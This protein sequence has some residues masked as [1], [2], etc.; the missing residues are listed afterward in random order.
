M[1]RKRRPPSVVFLTPAQI[2][3]RERREKALARAA[4]PPPSPLI[5]VGRSMVPRS[6]IAGNEVPVVVD[7]YGRVVS[8]VP[9]LAPTTIRAPRKPKKRTTTRPGPIDAADPNTPE[10]N[11]GSGA[12]ATK[13]TLP[14]Q[15]TTPA[16]TT[17]TTPTGPTPTET[18]K[19]QAAN[20]GLTK[21]DWRFARWQ[22]GIGEYAKYGPR[23][24]G[25]RPSGYPARTPQAGWRA[26]KWYQEHARQ[27]AKAPKKTTEP[28]ETLAAEETAAATAPAMTDQQFIN[29]WA[30]AFLQPELTAQQ[31][32]EARLLQQQ[33][34]HRA[35]FQHFTN[36]LM[37]ELKG[38]PAGV[39][40]DY[41]QAGNQTAALARESAAGLAAA[42]PNAQTQ[43]LMADVGAPASQMAQAAQAN[44]DVYQGGSAVLFGT[45]GHLPARDLFG[46]GASQTAYARML[47]A[48]GAAQAQDN[49]RAMGYTQSQERQKAADLRAQIEAKR[50]GYMLQGQEVLDKRRNDAAAI[51]IQQAELEMK[52]SAAEANRKFMEWSASDKSRQAWARIYGY[53]ERGNPTLDT[54]IADQRRTDQRAVEQRRA[55]QQA[56]STRLRMAS[57][58]GYD[59]ETMT[60]TLAQRQAEQR[61]IENDRKLKNKNK[62]GG[63]TTAQV[64]KFRQLA[65]ATAREA[66]YGLPETDNEEAVPPMTYQEAMNDL[67]MEM[68]LSIAQ[69]ALN[70]YYKRGDRG[71][72]WLDYQ[73]RQALQRAGL[74]GV[75]EGGPGRLSARQ[76]A[77]LK[78]AKLPTIANG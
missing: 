20:A 21:A 71:R 59:P 28:T 73:Q 57:I 53:D 61:A 60:P 41:T 30:Q 29:Q 43:Q 14:P 54:R 76:R 63:Y 38:I 72:P 42:N 33:E 12:G 44:Q 35:Q 78:A 62:K 22:L 4:A 52:L 9:G 69:R 16:T 40:A 11:A 50:P 31:Q 51:A 65:A 25:R 23:A 2:A 74:P 26:A 37:A 49:L 48:I 39:Q 8:P 36:A 55:E 70:R 6:V 68:P 75:P 64:I 47:P 24:A 10:P 5:G 56:M 77:A 19:D 66:Y 3:A 46:S 1:A 32:Q 45:E 17:R 13:G 27:P 18:A 15:A 34:M 58:F 7:Q 67:L